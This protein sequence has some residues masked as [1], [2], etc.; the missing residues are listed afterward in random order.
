MLESSCPYVINGH[1]HGRF[2]SHAAAARPSWAMEA[3]GGGRGRQRWGEAGAGRDLHVL[4]PPHTGACSHCWPCPGTHP[5]TQQVSKPEINILMPKS[6]VFPHRHKAPG[7]SILTLQLGVFLCKILPGHRGCLK[8]TLLLWPKL[9][10]D[11]ANGFEE[12]EVQYPLLSVFDINS[13]AVALRHSS[14][15]CPHGPLGSW[16]IAKQDPG[17]PCG[18]GILNV[19]V[20][21]GKY[22]RMVL[23]FLRKT[24]K[25]FFKPNQPAVCGDPP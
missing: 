18:G 25:K 17:T 22:W 6:V 7:G 19:V 11:L 16:V 24:F 12:K 2:R 21:L 10:L 5:N 15:E 14:W 8:V 20:Y 13:C 4:P 3:L 23:V 9:F 1:P